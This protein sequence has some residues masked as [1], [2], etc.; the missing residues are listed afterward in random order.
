MKHGKLSGTITPIEMCMKMRMTWSLE[1]DR[2][3]WSLKINVEIGGPHE[4]CVFMN[5][6]GYPHSI[7]RVRT[8]TSNGRTTIVMLCIALSWRLLVLTG[9]S[10]RGSQSMPSGVRTSWR[11]H[12]R[13]YGLCVEY[14]VHV[15]DYLLGQHSK[16]NETKDRSHHFIACDCCI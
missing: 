15:H 7:T 12:T 6:G 5:L 1:H 10:I 11:A 2:G 13:T 16:E 3:L 9:P 4:L 8:R 14:M